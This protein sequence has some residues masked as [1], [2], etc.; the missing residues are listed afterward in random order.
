MLYLMGQIFTCLVVAALIGGIVGWLLM[1]LR[2]RAAEQKLRSELDASND[3][4]KVA[5]GKTA[6]LRA[7]LLDAQK[8]LASKTRRLESRIEELEPYPDV[9]RRRE[10]TISRLQRKLRS[11]VSER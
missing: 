9:V 3:S 4:L 2:G 10:A 11:T 7:D 1:Q 8:R 6:S 5:R